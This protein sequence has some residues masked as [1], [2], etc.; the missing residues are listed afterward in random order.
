MGVL[1]SMVA[2]WVMA[3]A[4]VPGT[5]LL[6]AAGERSAANSAWFEV[7]GERF[8]FQARELSHGRLDLGGGV[9]AHR[10][11]LVNAERTLEAR[12]VL[13]A[14]GTA[15][16]LAGDYRAVSLADPAWQGVAGVGEVVLADDTDARRGRRLLPSGAGWIRVQAVEGGGLHVR[17]GI[18]GDDLFRPA[19]AAP[20]TGELQLG[21]AADGRPEL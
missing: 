21:A 15:G 20:V 9:S 17:F 5:A 18:L 13:Q 4:S 19:S 11:E 8:A 12:L 2:A 6:K 10:F 7:D 14:S 16:D 3:L 1:G